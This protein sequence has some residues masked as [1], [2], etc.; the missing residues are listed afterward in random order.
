MR[1]RLA[2]RVL[3]CDCDL[4]RK[5]IEDFKRKFRPYSFHKTWSRIFIDGFFLYPL[6]REVRVWPARLF[7]LQQKTIDKVNLPGADFCLA[8]GAA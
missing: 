6:G 1:G 7:F 3:P 5:T 8:I 2:V 4:E